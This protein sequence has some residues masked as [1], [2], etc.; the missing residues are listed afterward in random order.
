MA[1]PPNEIDA[2]FTIGAEAGNA[3]NVAVALTKYGRAL[4]QRHVITYWLSSD[5]TGD[6]LAA[7]PGTTAVGTNG[8]LL[9]EPT[10]DII[11]TLVTEAN[12]TFDLNITH[13]G[14]SGFYLNVV[15]PGSG[16][17]VTSP[18]VQFA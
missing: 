6:T 9:V 5:A 16:R 12:G 3:I 15:M 1:Q 2:A 18:I 13:A 17:V 10:D 11:G 4:D 7:D 14:T 8:T